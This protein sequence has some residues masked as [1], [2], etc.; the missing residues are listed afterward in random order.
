MKTN[1]EVQIMFY[2]DN[3]QNEVFATKE[4]NGFTE[5]EISES[6]KKNINLLFDK[7]TDVMKIEFEA[8][9]LIHRPVGTPKLLTFIK[10]R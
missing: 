5:K 9:E 8:T 7:H 1:W 4:F 6:C 3:N 2:R 10:K